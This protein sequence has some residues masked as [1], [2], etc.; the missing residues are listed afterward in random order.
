[1]SNNIRTNIFASFTFFA[2]LFA[3][4]VGVVEG[5]S[6]NPI[7]EDDIL[8]CVTVD[9]TIWAAPYSLR[10]ALETATG[11]NAT[12]EST[13]QLLNRLPQ[14]TGTNG[15]RF[16]GG[17]PAP[18]VREDLELLGYETMESVNPDVSGA[19]SAYELTL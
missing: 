10:H 6:D 12:I 9:D 11:K 13:T 8:A 17:E 7:D 15:V 3:A 1:M 14:A 5:Q 16:E 4:A 18:E 2:I 19:N